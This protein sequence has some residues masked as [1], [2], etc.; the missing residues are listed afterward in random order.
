MPFAG[1]LGL[2][3][4][5]DGCGQIIES[6]GYT[7]PKELQGDATAN[8]R[9]LSPEYPLPASSTACASGLWGPHSAG[10]ATR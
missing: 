2:Y 7:I 5:N 10:A 6:I 3:T 1:E 8:F 4:S 9:E